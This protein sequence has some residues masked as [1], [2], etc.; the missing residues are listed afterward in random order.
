MLTCKLNSINHQNI[1]SKQF[2]SLSVNFSA[3]SFALQ[4]AAQRSWAFRLFQFVSEEQVPSVQTILSNFD[5]RG[6]RASGRHGNYNSCYTL[7]ASC[8]W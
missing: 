4:F 8:L 2:F 1:F 3:S 5:P 6:I 7:N